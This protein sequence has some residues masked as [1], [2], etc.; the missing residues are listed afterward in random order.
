M[1]GKNIWNETF[2]PMPPPSPPPPEQRNPGVDYHPAMAE[3]AQGSTALATR[4]EAGSL[5][6]LV[7]PRQASWR[8]VGVVLAAEALAGV[9][10][11]LSASAWLGFGVLFGIVFAWSFRRR[12]D[13]HVALTNN[14]RARELLD[15]GEVEQAEALLDAVLA[16][17]RTPVNIR[18]FAAYYRAL[19]AMR[20]G[21]YPEARSRLEG[22]IDSG[23]LANRRALQNLAPAIY[24][25]A[26]LAAVLDGDLEAA[27]EWR[28]AGRRCPANLE[29]HWFVADGFALAR[30]ERWEELLRMLDRR[31]D[32]IEGTVSGAGIRQLQLLQALAISRLHEREDNYRGLH[33]GDEVRAL[34]HGIR[35]G[36]FRHLAT[37]WPELAEFMQA[38]GL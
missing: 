15:I 16:N 24:A 32:A 23:W 34:I 33:S 17:R 20:R 30:R 35:P 14:E 2:H 5:P 13:L 1:Y 37:K 12:S 36:R 7:T 4:P 11:A 3:A 38:H 8:A 26:T 22:V 21:D 10:W 29:R 25:A 18:P 6:K 28:A 9:A 31:W 19:A 27:D